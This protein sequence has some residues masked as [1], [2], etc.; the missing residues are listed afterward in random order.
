MA[1]NM[2]LSSCIIAED[3]GSAASGL[4]IGIVLGALALISIVLCVVYVRREKKK[5]RG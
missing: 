1:K 4:V 5:V 2:M 3:S